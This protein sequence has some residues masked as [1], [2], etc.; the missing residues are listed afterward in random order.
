MPYFGK[1]GGFKML[2]LDSIQTMK[3]AYGNG[4]VKWY[5][6]FQYV[7]EKGQSTPLSVHLCVTATD[8]PTDRGGTGNICN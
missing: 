4:N 7:T 2:V 8:P 3:Q 6:F 5:L 1:T